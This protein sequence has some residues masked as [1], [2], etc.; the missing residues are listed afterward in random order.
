MF[1]PVIKLNLEKFN[2]LLASKAI[3]LVS[4]NP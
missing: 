2:T 4:D 3:A 1:I